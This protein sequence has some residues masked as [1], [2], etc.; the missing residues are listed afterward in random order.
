ME[1]KILLLPG[2][3]HI[4]CSRMSPVLWNPRR[5]EGLHQHGFL[6]AQGETLQ[7]VSQLIQDGGVTLL[8]GG[9][10]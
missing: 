6:G 2:F 5:R 3:L 1:I 8:R 9:F 10:V 7:H 4:S